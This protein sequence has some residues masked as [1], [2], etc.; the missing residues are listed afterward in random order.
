MAGF[1]FKETMSGTWRRVREGGGGEGD[2]A[3]MHFTIGVRAGS[4]F[5]HLRDKKAEID[6]HV[7]LAGLAEKAAITGEITINPLFGRLIRYEFSFTG[8]DG[9][10]YRFRGQK[11]VSL[12]DVVRTMTTLPGEIVDA[13]EKLVGRANLLFDKR[14]LPAFL[15]SFRPTF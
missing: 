10:R 9:K 1:H 13:A 8:D 2:E 12:R 3:T 5:Q 6:G 15:G 4:L 7:H 14:H 11:D